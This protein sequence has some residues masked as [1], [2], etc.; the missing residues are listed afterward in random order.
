MEPKP[1]GIRIQYSIPGHNFVHDEHKVEAIKS[2]GYH[3]IL[4]QC[5]IKGINFYPWNLAGLLGIS[6][7]KTSI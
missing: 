5:N 3:Y 7:L 6:F 2:I 4:N 1:I